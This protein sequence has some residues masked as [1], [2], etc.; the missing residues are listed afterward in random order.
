MTFAER[1]NP[2]T[3]SFCPRF[4]ALVGAIIGYDY[5]LRDGRGGKWTGVSITSEG[6]VIAATTAH[7]SGAFVGPAEDLERNI[8]VFINLLD[9]EDR[10]EFFGR[11]AAR[12]RDLRN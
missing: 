1:I 4:T 11:Y 3:K 12:V 5:G 10:N 9:E 7:P 2:S 6:I 8:R